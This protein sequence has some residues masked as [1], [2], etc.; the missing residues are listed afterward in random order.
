MSPSR[1]ATTSITSMMDTG[2]PPMGTT[3]TST[4]GYWRALTC[5]RKR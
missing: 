4:D 5:A 2:T 1:M 3:T